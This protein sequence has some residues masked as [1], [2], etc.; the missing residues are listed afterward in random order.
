MTKNG[1]RALFILVATIANMLLTI[2]LIVI[3]LVLWNLLAQGLGIPTNTP[4]PFF[5]AFLAAIVLSG[6]AYGKFLKA[7]Q[8]NPKLSERFGLVK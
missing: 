4:I 3:L 6:L 2:I 5:V 8:K 7:M 1:R